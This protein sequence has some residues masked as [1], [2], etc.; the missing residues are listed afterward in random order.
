LMVMLK[1][2]IVILVILFGLPYVHTSSLHPFIPPN[3]GSFGKFGVSGVLAASGMIFF[4]YIG[5]EAV[6]VAA[7][8]AKNP[9]RDLPIGILGSLGICTVLYI[10][11]AIVLTGITDWRTLDVANPVSFAIGKISNLGW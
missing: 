9:R 11:M 10:G 7:L 3:E 8:E 1:T 4:A 2:G 5:F 6:S